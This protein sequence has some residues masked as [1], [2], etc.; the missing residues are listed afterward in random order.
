NAIPAT[1]AGKLPRT[2]EQYRTL[3][4]RMQHARPAVEGARQQSEALA[5]QAAQL[6]Q[7]LVDTAAK[8]QSLEETKAQIDIGIVNLAGREN[9]LSGNFARDRAKV[10]RLL[11]VLE[12]LQ[13][14]LPPALAVG[15][16]DALRSARGAMLLGA[17][18]PRV[19]GAAAA[20]SRQLKALKETR[21]ALLKRREESTRTAAQL[22]LAR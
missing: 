12:R 6:R 1:Q 9:V 21:A 11:A 7:R 16:A 14:D 18:L 20:L 15:P 17:A 5:A 2:E 3:Q 13:S 8:I 4:R 22:T 10:S 19:Y